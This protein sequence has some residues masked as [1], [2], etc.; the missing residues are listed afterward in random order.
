M[1]GTAIRWS[2]RLLQ[3][4]CTRG[5][6]WPRI[7]CR[8]QSRCRQ[9][10]S[11]EHLQMQERSSH[12]PQIGA[13]LNIPKIDFYSFLSHGQMGSAKN[14]SEGS[15]SWGWTSPDGRELVAVGQSDGAAFVEISKEGK[16]LY[17][18]RLPQYSTPAIWREIRGYKNYMV[19]G[20]EAVGHNIQVFDMTKV[21]P[22]DFRK[23]TRRL[24][25]AAS[26][27]R[28]QNPHHLPQSQRR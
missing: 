8:W 1:G 7:L 5:G 21:G 3:V 26:H 22:H 4:E 19:I 23:K 10:R 9:G 25:K 11:V 14:Q 18:G 12:L 13:F 20:S 27:D 16:L 6:R 15:S 24:M 2:F 17:L 28:P